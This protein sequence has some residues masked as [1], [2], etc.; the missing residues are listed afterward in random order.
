M[1]QQSRAQQ[2]CSGINQASLAQPAVIRFVMLQSEVSHVI[3]Q[4]EQKVIIAVV[5]RSK[6]RVGLRDQVLVMLP[7]L[8]RSIERG[9]TVGSNVHF[10]GRSLSRIEGDN[11]Q[12]LSSDD[13]AIDQHG[14]RNRGKLY[15]CS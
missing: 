7:N 2:P 14:Q 9:R 1:R 10:R 15:F 6:Q 13:G 12:I 5:L 11:F 3:T 8:R 4:A